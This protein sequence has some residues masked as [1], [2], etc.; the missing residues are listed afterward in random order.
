MI[1]DI[2]IVSIAES[3]VQNQSRPDRPPGVLTQ[4]I[5][6]RLIKKPITQS[7]SSSQAPH[8]L[9]IKRSLAVNLTLNTA[10]ACCTQH[11]QHALLHVL[12]GYDDSGNVL[13]QDLACI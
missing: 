9:H 10:T 8:A 4:C 1:T 12:Q 6:T 7:A 11:M 3:P 2:L 5:Y 13:P